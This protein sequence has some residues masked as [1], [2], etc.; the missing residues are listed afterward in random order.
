MTK[1]NEKNSKHNSKTKNTKNSKTSNPITGTVDPNMTK[2]V[3]GLS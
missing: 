2:P 3:K 1:N